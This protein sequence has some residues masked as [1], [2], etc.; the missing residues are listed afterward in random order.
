MMF[1]RRSESSSG[2]PEIQALRRRPNSL[3]IKDVEDAEIRLYE[4]RVGKKSVGWVQ[5]VKAGRDA[6]VANLKVLPS[7]HRRGLGRALM[8]ALLS[9]DAR[10]GRRR[11]VLLASHAGAMLYPQLGYQRIGTLMLLMPM[12]ATQAKRSLAGAGKRAGRAG[13]TG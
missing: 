12:P 11:S 1:S 13:S 10:L 7:H 4:A 9:D 6:W 3:G 2:R 5:S 8:A